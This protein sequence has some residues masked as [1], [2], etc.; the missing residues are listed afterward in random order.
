M[1][2]EMGRLRARSLE[3]LAASDGGDIDREVYFPGGARRTS[4][5]VPLRLW[6]R[7]WSK[8]DMLHGQAIVRTVPQLTANADFRSWLADD[9]ILEALNREAEPRTERGDPGVAN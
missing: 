8:H 5:M 3:L 9:P 2:T 4:G 1:L 7:S 6:L